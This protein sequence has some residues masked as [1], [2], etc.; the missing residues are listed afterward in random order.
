MIHMAFQI[1]DVRRWDTLAPLTLTSPPDDDPYPR[2]KLGQF[3]ITPRFSGSIPHVVTSVAMLVDQLAY[4]TRLVWC[5]ALMG[6]VF[7]FLRGYLPV[8]LR[9][10]QVSWSST[11]HALIVLMSA[12]YPTRNTTYQTRHTKRAI[13]NAPYRT[14]HP[15]AVQL[16]T[17]HTRFH[18]VFCLL[19]ALSALRPPP[20]VPCL[21][22]TSTSCVAPF[23]APTPH[24]APHLRALC[25][26][27][28]D[29]AHLR[30]N[31]YDRRHALSFRMEVP[32]LP[33]HRPSALSHRPYIHP[34]CILLDLTNFR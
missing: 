18:Q 31:L 21:R 28:F 34:I 7:C 9:S 4:S 19:S 5:D 33:E 17:A 32:M 30:R 16:E 12:G 6:S 13:P 14:R 11:A 10:R 25:S 23:A 20:P 8:R 26:E 22:L 29:V 3:P 15:F 2:I 27:D 24:P 1:D